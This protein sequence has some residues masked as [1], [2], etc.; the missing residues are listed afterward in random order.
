MLYAWLI[1][2]A[3]TSGWPKQLT[4]TGKTGHLADGKGEPEAEQGHSSGY[5]H[6]C[7][8]GNRFG[9]GILQ[10][11]LGLGKHHTTRCARVVCG[12]PADSRA[13]LPRNRH[14]IPRAGVSRLL[15]HD[16]G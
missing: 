12:A 7:R 10:G 6:A 8:G 11:P 3:I 14:A 16:A 13:V 2:A 5:R 15:Q 9:I 1:T 4:K